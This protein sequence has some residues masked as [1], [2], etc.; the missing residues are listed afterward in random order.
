MNGAMTTSDEAQR[1]ALAEFLSERRARL[2]PAQFGIAAGSR[3][4]TPGL[5]REEVAHLAGISATW[6][7]WIEQ[8]RGV[9]VSPGVVA[10]LAEVLQLSPAERAYLFEQ[11]GKR[12]PREPAKD[13]V[14]D[15]PPALATAVESFAGP[16][17]VLDRLGTARLWNRA[18]SR[19]FT[20][21]LD[22]DED[23][24]LLRFLFT[25]RSARELIVDWSERSR[26]VV[27]EFR[28]DNTRH[29]GEP[30]VRALVDELTA[31]SRRFAAIW[32]EQAVMGREGGERRF[33]HPT[34]GAL[35]YTQVGFIVAHRPDL[36][37]VLL[38][39][40]AAEAR[41]AAGRSPRRRRSR[42]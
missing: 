16:A 12:D 4:R 27:A 18:A 15:L 11:A 33:L 24:S 5:R 36:K 25:R 19:L 30:E 39:D 26:R 37:L 7:T 32:R 3:R 20:G 9:S 17:Y 6:Y 28:A 42:A 13:A 35:V 29:L 1:R 38:V 22:G 8:G 23:R 40:A 41:G 14:A 34:R 10:R 21:W 2:V 31:R